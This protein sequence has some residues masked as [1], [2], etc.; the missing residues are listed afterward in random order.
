MKR[1]GLA[2]LAVLAVVVAVGGTVMAFDAFLGGDDC[3]DVVR[4][5]EREEASIQSMKR[6]L[7]AASL[8][9]DPV[10]AQN[11]RV[12]L[13]KRT[14]EAIERIAVLAEQHPGCFTVEDRMEW[15]ATYRRWRAGMDDQ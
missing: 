13:T 8:S 5:T 9:R 12:K 14:Y 1:A 2:A 10:T 7:D 15:E 4:L 3:T 11:K 6:V